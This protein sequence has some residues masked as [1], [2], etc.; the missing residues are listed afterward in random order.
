MYYI[1]LS[2]CCFFAT[3]IVVY[4]YH[5]ECEMKRHLLVILRTCST[6]NMLNDTGSGRYIQV[7]KHQLVNQCVSSLVH[8][9]NQVKNHA[10]EMVVLDDHSTEESIADVRAILKH[11]LFPVEYI[12]VEDGTGNGHTMGKVYEIVEAR[13]KDLWYHVE[14]DYLHDEEAIEDMLASYT[15]FEQQTGK[16]VAINPHDDIWRYRREIYPSFLLLGPG[17]H[18]RTVQHTTYTCLASKKIYD[19]YRNHFQDVVNLTKQRADWVENK[20]INLV[21]QKEDVALFSPIPGLAFHIMDPSGQ[22]PYVDIDIM[23]DRV[24]KLWQTEESTQFAIVSMYNEGHKDLGSISW[25]NKV[26]YAEKHGYGHF[27]KTDDFTNPVSI[28]FEKHML[29]LDL[30]EANPD[31]DWVWWLDNDAIITNYDIKLESIV[32]P[33]YHVIM[34]TDVATVNGGCFIVRNSRQGREWL[35]FMLD[36]GMKEYKDNR[37]P[38]QQPMADFFI[39]YRDIVKIVPQRTMNSYD[40]RIYGVDGIDQLGQSG[41]WQHGDFVI[42]FPAL[43]NPARIQLM[44]Q[45]IPQIVDT[46]NENI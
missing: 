41:Q 34:T 10:I 44:N 21:W 9:L 6:V 13:A 27:C 36:I 32:D 20:S 26:A 25:P 11:C 1:G 30:M 42:H 16:M 45:Y 5:K 12:S 37:W 38:D 31:L 35:Q 18:Y 3:V 14:D 40:Y 39:K 7:P 2:T 4:K 28:Q 17:R 19:S 22:D 15:Q 33:D 46:T 23:W 43:P 8:S 29:M 24:P